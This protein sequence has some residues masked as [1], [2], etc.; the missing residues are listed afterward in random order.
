MNMFM[1]RFL[2]LLLANVTISS[3]KGENSEDISNQ[4][5][6]ADKSTN[7]VNLA[8]CD[9]SLSKEEK[10]G[11]KT[12]EEVHTYA[13]L[14][15]D[16][17]ASLPDHFTVC[18]SIMVSDCKSSTWPIFFNI[19]DSE[20]VQFLV[21][22]HGKRFKALFDLG[23]RRDNSEMVS[24]KV[25]PLFPNRWTRGCIAVNITSGLISWIVEGTLIMSRE[26]V[27]IRNSSGRPKDLSRKL[28]LGAR[29]YGGFWKTTN[30]KV[31]NLN[32]FSSFL[33]IEKMKNLTSERSCDYMG[34]YLAWK[35]MEWIIHGHARVETAEREETCQKEPVVDFYFSK[36]QGMQSCMHHCQNLGSRVPS[37][38]PFVEWTKL[39]AFLKE[40]L[41]DKGLYTQMWLPIKQ[42]NEAFWEDFYTGEMLQ[43]LQNGTH[44][45][46]ELKLKGGQAQN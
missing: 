42:K 29:W 36:F 25:P 34:D 45:G 41:F 35:D 33:S 7:V 10:M 6:K 26:F 31:T 40:K 11:K 20:G 39:R 32:I 12:L 21:P 44:P 14:K 4:R 3:V 27:E 23:F 9:S 22:Y 37:V 28:V 30:I 38:F 19:L 46:V 8:F 1:L 17:Q 5:I 24:R 2:I 16:P 43:K 15:Q 13:Q 18:A